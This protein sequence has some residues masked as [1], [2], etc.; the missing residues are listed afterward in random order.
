MMETGQSDPW[1]TGNKG[2]EQGRL[3]Y[4]T[5]VSVIQL[6]SFFRDSASECCCSGRQRVSNTGGPQ[7]S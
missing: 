5:E 2:E 7:T 4:C 6:P 1:S 3:D